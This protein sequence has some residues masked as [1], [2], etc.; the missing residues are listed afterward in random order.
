[1]VR[2]NK[3]ELG[4]KLAAKIRGY[5]KALGSRRILFIGATEGWGSRKEKHISPDPLKK[6]GITF[7]REG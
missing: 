2:E 5:K 1:V 6:G 7:K 4:R 3:E